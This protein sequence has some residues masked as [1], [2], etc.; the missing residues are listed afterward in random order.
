M[1]AV[2]PDLRKR[3]LPCNSSVT[4]SDMVAAYLLLSEQVLCNDLGDTHLDQL[5]KKHLTRDPVRRLERSGYSDEVQQ[6]QEQ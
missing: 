4:L 1:M 2:H 5:S 3:S 6:A